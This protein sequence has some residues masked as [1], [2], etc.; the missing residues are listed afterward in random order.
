MLEGI[1]RGTDLQPYD[2]IWLKSIEPRDF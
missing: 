2:L 1:S